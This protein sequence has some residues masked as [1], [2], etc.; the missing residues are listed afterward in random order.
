VHLAVYEKNVGLTNHIFRIVLDHFSSEDKFLICEE[1]KF[2]LTGLDS[3]DYRLAPPHMSGR[4]ALMSSTQNYHYLHSN[5]NAYIATLTLEMG[6]SIFSQ[7]LI[8]TAKQIFQKN[9]YTASNIERPI[10]EYCSIFE[11]NSKW[12]RRVVKY[13]SN[14][15]SW[16]I[17]SRRRPDALFTYALLLSG[18]FRIMLTGF[19]HLNLHH[20][21]FRGKNLNAK[22]KSELRIHAPQLRSLNGFDFCVPCEMH[23]LSARSPVNFLD[24]YEARCRF[25]IDELAVKRLK[26]KLVRKH[27]VLP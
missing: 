5:E 20:L 1:D 10:R 12:E 2:Y 15:F 4:H 21:D 23:T 14:Y 9:S 27:K 18:R 22:P 11:L 26:S 7:D 17:T 13:W 16:G 8:Q 25:L 19:N 24:L 3:L 6:L